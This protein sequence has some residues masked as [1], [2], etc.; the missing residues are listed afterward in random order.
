MPTAVS[1][2]ITPSLRNVVLHVEPAI[3]AD[4][5]HWFGF[6]DYNQCDH[7]EYAYLSGSEGP[8]VE[9]RRGFDIEALELKVALDFGVGA[10]DW[11]GCY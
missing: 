5:K 3:S 1:T 7:F 10:I 11:R 2:A 8:R 4:K 9:Q 6:T